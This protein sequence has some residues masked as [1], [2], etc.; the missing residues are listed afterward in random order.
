MDETK[1]KLIKMMIAVKQAEENKIF[2]E[3]IVQSNK[4]QFYLTMLVLLNSSYP[5]KNIKSI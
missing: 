1:E 2:G 5:D 4:V 3:F